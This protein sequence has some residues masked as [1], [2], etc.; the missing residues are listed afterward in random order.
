M[1]NA[2]V[3]SDPYAAA[4]LRNI[5]Q[6]TVDNYNVTTTGQDEWYPVAFFLRDESGEGI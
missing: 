3:I 6:T 4:D 1:R 2:T 5:V